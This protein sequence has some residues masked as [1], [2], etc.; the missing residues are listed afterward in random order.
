MKHLPN[1]ETPIFF[2]IFKSNDGPTREF[3]EKENKKWNKRHRR[4]NRRKDKLKKK[5]FGFNI[6]SE[7][8]TTKNLSCF[9]FFLLLITWGKET[10]TKLRHSLGDLSF[11]RS[12]L[13]NHHHSSCVCRKRRE[14]DTEKNYSSP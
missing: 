6:L 1:S 2:K 11:L 13:M 12:F 9:S 7:R 10:E 5:L 3:W 14:S 4:E 8:T